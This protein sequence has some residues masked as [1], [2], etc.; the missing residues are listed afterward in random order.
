MSTE[1]HGDSRQCS[2]HPAGLPVTRLAQG[3]AGAYPWVRTGNPTLRLPAASRAG[4]DQ[5]IAIG[6]A[7]DPVAPLNFTG[8]RM[9]QNSAMPASTSGA[10]RRFSMR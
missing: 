6:R 10:S 1:W 7:G 3:R 2:V 8:S 5:T 9:K 4:I